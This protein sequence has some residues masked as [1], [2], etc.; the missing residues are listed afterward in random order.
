[1]AE[2]ETLPNPVMETQT[3]PPNSVEWMAS[4]FIA[5]DKSAG[6]Y[7]GLAIVGVILAVLIYLITGDFISVSVVVIGII[8]LG[9]Y[10]ARQPRQLPYRLD[11]SGVSIGNKTYAYGDFRSFA[12]LPEGAFS[13]IVF[14]PLK[15]FSP[16][17]TIYY[18]PTDEEKIMAI[19]SQELPFEEHKRDAVDKLMRRIGF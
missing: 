6:W 17:I 1:M 19:L 4:E 3:A 7:T 10:G 16:P 13:S 5:H 12:V 14:M 11:R 18:A 15:R 8:L 9:I 2:S